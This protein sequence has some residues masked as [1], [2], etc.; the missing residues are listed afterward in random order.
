MNNKIVYMVSSFA[1]ASTSLKISR[2]V[3]AYRSMQSFD[4][5]S[6]AL[7]PAAKMAAVVSMVPPPLP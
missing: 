7:R 6:A 4:R 1:N 2:T 5:G 3:P